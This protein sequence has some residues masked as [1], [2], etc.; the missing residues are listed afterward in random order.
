MKRLFLLRH[1]KSS[2][3]DPQM[4]DRDRP[5]N[6]RG[7]R[8]APRMAAYMRAKGY[9][10]DMALCSPSN[11]TRQTLD[12]ITSVIGNFPISYPEALYLGEAGALRA[13]LTGVDDK[14]KALLLVGHNPGMGTLVS[15]LTDFESLDEAHQVSRFPTAAL[16]VFEA[17]TKHWADLKEGRLKLVDFMTPKLLP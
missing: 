13:A 17:K 11:R 7:M 5:L 14:V 4:A 16:A 8:D 10:P 1:A 6:A 15:Q 12:A 9:V 2:W 3:D